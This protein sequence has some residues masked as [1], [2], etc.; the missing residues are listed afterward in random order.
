MYDGRGAF[1]GF[2]KTFY[3]DIFSGFDHILEIVSMYSN[4]NNTNEPVLHMKTSSTEKS[5]TLGNVLE[6]V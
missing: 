1:T 3:K 6:S 5:L 2:K 4:K